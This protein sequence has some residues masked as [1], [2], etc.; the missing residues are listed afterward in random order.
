MVLLCR[1]R[2]AGCGKA[3]DAGNERRRRGGYGGPIS[4]SIR[5]AL[6]SLGV[7]GSERIVT[8]YWDSKSPVDGRGPIFSRFLG[9][10]YSLWLTDK[11][12]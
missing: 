7:L 1:G 11:G 9:C 4:G 10:C 2:D 5:K 6:R 3:G 8:V 12:P